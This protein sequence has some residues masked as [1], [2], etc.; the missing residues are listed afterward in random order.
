MMDKSNKE[1]NFKDNRI[2]SC[3]ISLSLIWELSIFGE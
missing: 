3:G 1:R 2:S